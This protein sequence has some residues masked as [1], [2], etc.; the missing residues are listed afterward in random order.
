MPTP[1]RSWSLLADL[2]HG[3]VRRVEIIEARPAVLDDRLGPGQHRHTTATMVCCLRGVFRMSHHGGDIDLAPGEMVVVAPGAWHNHCPARGDSCFWAQGVLP[4]GSDLYV[5]DGG[6]LRLSVVPVEPS[7]G[8]LAAMIEE[9]DPIRRCELATRLA[10]LALA[11]GPHRPAPTP[12]QAR[13]AKFIWRNVHRPVSVAE[14]LDA[15]GLCRRQAQRRFIAYFGKGPKQAM[16]AM[17][18]VLARRLR[19]EGASISE[20]AA[21]SG[22]PGRAALTRAW[23]AA[24][25]CAPRFDRTGASSLALQPSAASTRAVIRPKPRPRRSKVQAAGAPAPLR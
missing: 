21:A 11:G 12:D 22:F 25:G 13:M 2:A 17:R 14:V 20:A 15:S 4:H 24:Y 16:T 8:V 1:D 23:R 6:D 18:L 5:C 7:A 10:G 3:G 9:P 19:D